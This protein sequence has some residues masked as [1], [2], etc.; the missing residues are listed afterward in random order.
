MEF[1]PGGSLYMHMNKF[2]DDGEQRIK[3]PI[4]MD[5][6]KFYAA[7]LVLAICHLHA[8]DIVYR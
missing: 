8:C 7:Q 5:R 2:S 6:I 3:V 4:D 1:Y